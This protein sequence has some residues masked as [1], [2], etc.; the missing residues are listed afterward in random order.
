[1]EKLGNVQMTRYKA[2]GHYGFRRIRL[3]G[4]ERSGLNLLLEKLNILGRD[5]RTKNIP[6]AYFLADQETICHFL[7]GLWVTDG[8]IELPRG[9][10]TFASASEQLIS[11]IQHLLLRLGIIARVRKSALKERR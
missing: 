8:C 11:D 1:V 2:K 5:A 7:A 4:H 9:N 3:M 10:I 6:A